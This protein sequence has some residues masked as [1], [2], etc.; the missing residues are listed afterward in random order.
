[1]RNQKITDEEGKTDSILLVTFFQH[2][3]TIHTMVLQLTQSD[4]KATMHFFIIASVLSFPC[5]KV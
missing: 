5:S 3:V 4:G 2:Q 1:M